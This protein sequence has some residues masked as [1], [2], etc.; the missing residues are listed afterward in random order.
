MTATSRLWRSPRR[1][2]ATVMALL[3]S[4]FVAGNIAAHDPIAGASRQYAAS[5]QTLEWKYYGTYSSWL[6][7]AVDD[8][9]HD[10]AGN[11]SLWDDAANNN[12]RLQS[13]TKTSSGSGRIRYISD[14][15]SPCTGS[16]VW[17]MCADNDRDGDGIKSDWYI[18]IR[19]FDGAPYDSAGVAWRWRDDGSST[20]NVT[21]DVR[22][23]ALHEAIHITMGVGGHDPQSATVTL[24]TSVSPDDND[25]GWNTRR[26]EQCDHARAQMIFDIELNSG[27]IANCFDHVSNA[28]S[29]GLKSVLSLSTPDT[30]VCNGATVTL[31][32]L[33]RLGNY[34]AYGALAAEP[35]GS[36]TVSIKRDDVAYASRTTGTSSGTYSLT[37]TRPS[38]GSDTF[39]SSF[40]NEGAE[41]VT[42]DSSSAVTVTWSPYPTCEGPL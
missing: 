18:F 42:G 31:T 32:G 14:F 39:V 36:R 10:T 7:T 15:T 5:D 34:A 11:N 21:F 8:A 6:T 27:P 12:S 19:N 22:R 24:M 28:G 3:S 33:L 37:A 17:I 25:A 1:Q 38:S 9:L 4:F 35:L 2:A 13:F 16:Q 29:N 30:T 23:N 40:A 20:S 26:L 41:A